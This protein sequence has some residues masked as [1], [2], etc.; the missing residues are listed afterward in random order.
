MVQLHPSSRSCWVCVHFVFQTSQ[1][2]RQAWISK[3]PQTPYLYLTYLLTLYLF[4]QNSIKLTFT[5]QE[6][7]STLQ[8]LQNRFTSL[9][10]GSPVELDLLKAD[11][12]KE[13]S[14]VNMFIPWFQGQL[15]ESLVTSLGLLSFY[16]SSAHWSLSSEW[17]DCF[18][19]PHVL[20]SKVTL[21]FI[22]FW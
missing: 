20:W 15:Q 21:W 3:N 1:A 14:L 9:A 19:S 6:S 10:P 11:Q 16:P 7:M 2:T 8:L 4:Q 13:N 22:N 5:T 18:P 17:H 12:V